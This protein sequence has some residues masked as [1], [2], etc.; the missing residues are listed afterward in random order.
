M[1]DIFQF[2]EAGMRVVDP[3]IV[4]TLCLNF[5]NPAPTKSDKSKVDFF[6]RGN[7]HSWHN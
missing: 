3:V 6:K 7:K 5:A 2:P 4:L 1:F